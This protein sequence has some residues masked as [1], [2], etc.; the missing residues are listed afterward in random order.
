[1]LSTPRRLAAVAACVVLGL[2][3]C[4]D[5][6][7]GSVRDLNEGEGGSASASGS[8]SGS[9]SGSSSGSA[10]ASA[11]GTS[12]AECSPVGTELEGDASETVEVTLT[13][14][15]FE[16]S[17]FEV[18]AGIVTFVASNDGEE[19]HELALLPGGGEVPTTED[20]APDEAALEEAG[21]FELE[22]FAPGG[23]CNATFDLEPGTYTIFCLVEAPDGL[24]HA[25]KG[26]V[27]ELTVS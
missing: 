14:Y 7:G 17:E 2:A 16:P 3:A 26:M 27:G 12:A 10:S 25:D 13:E 11:S 20:G 8:A 22:A 9:V 5:D 21:A 6:D 15:E 1:M 4:G 24:T 23:S 19:N 18:A